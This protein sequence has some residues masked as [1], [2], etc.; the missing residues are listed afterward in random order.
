MAST[1]TILGIIL[2]GIVTVIGGI[3]FLRLHA[4]VALVL[5]AIFVGLL[6]PASSVQRWSLHKSAVNFQAS[7]SDSAG[8][9]QH[10]AFNETIGQ[11]TPLQVVRF[12]SQ[13]GRHESIGTLAVEDSGTSAVFHPETIGTAIQSDDLVVPSSAVAAAHRLSGQTVGE[14][15]AT[16]FGSTCAKIGILIA[17][18]SIVGK[19]LLDSGAADRIVRSALGVLG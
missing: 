1:T 18:A 19:C 16:G 13:T 17:L 11:D 6:T 9:A 3:L 5:G 2:V 7:L 4:F 15:V 8:A 14:R 10:V 12:S